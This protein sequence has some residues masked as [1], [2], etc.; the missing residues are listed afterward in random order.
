MSF[1]L[2]RDHSREGTFYQKCEL[3]VEGKQKHRCREPSERVHHQ[4]FDGTHF[5][6]LL[7]AGFLLN[8][9]EKRFDGVSHTAYGWLRPLSCVKLAVT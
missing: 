4:S 1:S 8:P 6:G 9:V 2:D 5:G 3:R 7:D